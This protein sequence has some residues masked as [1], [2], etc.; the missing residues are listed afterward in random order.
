MVDTGSVEMVEA[1]LR[2][3]TIM[4]MFMIDTQI[5]SLEAE[6]EATDI[7]DIREKS[8][9]GYVENTG[10]DRLFNVLS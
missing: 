1:L 9:F 2:E 10:D 4:E 5:A 3:A 6:L 7:P 8:S